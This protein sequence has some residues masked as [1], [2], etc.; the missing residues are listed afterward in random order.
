MQISQ[1]TSYVALLNGWAYALKDWFD[2]KFEKPFSRE[3][4]PNKYVSMARTKSNYA[5][6]DEC[7]SYI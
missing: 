7:R 5:R 1:R 2:R 4:P 6:F 3:A